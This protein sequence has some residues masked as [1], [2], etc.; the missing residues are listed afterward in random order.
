VVAVYRAHAPGYA[1]L[2]RRIA[3]S[4]CLSDEEIAIVE[5]R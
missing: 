5:G 4:D 2:A 3:A 1:E